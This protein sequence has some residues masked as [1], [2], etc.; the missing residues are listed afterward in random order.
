[1]QRE[2]PALSAASE[3]RK[4]SRS[5]AGG[6]VV[7]IPQPEP[8]DA[9]R[10]ILCAREIIRLIARWN[11]KRGFD[12]PVRVGIGLHAARRSAACSAPGSGWS[13]QCWATW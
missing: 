2:F 1:M 13:S 5:A 9:R 11:A 6:V 10:A 4:A 3:S 7:G 12:P 8:D